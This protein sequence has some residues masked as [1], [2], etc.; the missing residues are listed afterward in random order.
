MSKE[1]KKYDLTDEEVNTLRGFAFAEELVMNAI[2]NDKAH[3][4]ETI[5]VTRLGYKPAEKRGFEIEG[6]TLTVQEFEKEIVT[7]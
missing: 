7:S 5:C 1:P 2:K 3:Y 6:K 4:L